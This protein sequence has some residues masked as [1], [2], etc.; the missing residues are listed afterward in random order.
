MRYKVLV[1]F[2]IFTLA[3][4]PVR[5]GIKGGRKMSP[6]CNPFN[7]PGGAGEWLIEPASDMFPESCW[8]YHSIPEFDMLDYY[9]KLCHDGE[10]ASHW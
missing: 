10:Q 7:Y 5:S 9:C 2:A 6:I 1:C 3:F 4:V 8:Y